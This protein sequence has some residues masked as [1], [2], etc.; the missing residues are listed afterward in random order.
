MRVPI[1][2]I[3]K[4]Y[5]RVVRLY[6]KRF[7][8]EFGEEMKQVFADAVAEAVE[9]GRLPLIVVCLRELRDLPVIALCEHWSGLRD[10]QDLARSASTREEETSMAGA[11]Q[12][13]PVT[14]QG[15]PGIALSLNRPA[16]LWPNRMSSLR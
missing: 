11:L 10:E 1:P 14:P 7:R 8:E 12:G 9:R 15:A 6:P 5:G 2:Q 13:M 16:A 3:M 4:A